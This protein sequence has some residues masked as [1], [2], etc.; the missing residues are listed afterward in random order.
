MSDLSL[1][2]EMGRRERGAVLF[3]ALIF[4]IL[5]TLLALTAMGSSILQEKMTGGMRNRQLSLMGAESGLRGGESYLW[6]LNFSSVG[7]QPLPPC[8]TGNT[9]PCVYRTRRNGTLDQNVQAFRTA[10]TWQF[11]NAA[12]A[13]VAL[14]LAGSLSYTLPLTGLTGTAETASLSAAPY[15]AI[16]DLGADVPAGAGVQAGLIDPE[17]AGGAGTAWLY[18]ITSRS[19][20]GSAAVLRTAESVFSSANLTN[21]GR[22]P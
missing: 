19:Q 2:P 3:V 12:G 10:K 8:V 13:T 20:G 22:D 4:L 9:N 1:I 16:E 15:L 11:Q 14:P 17:R 21:T 18:R 7:G 5:L 6:N